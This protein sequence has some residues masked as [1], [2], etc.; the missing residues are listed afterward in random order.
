VDIPR[1]AVDAARVLVDLAEPLDPADFKRL[2]NNHVGPHTYEM[3]PG[4]LAWHNPTP[5]P[6]EGDLEPVDTFTAWQALTTRNPYVRRARMSGNPELPEVVRLDGRNDIGQRAP[7]ALVAHPA[8]ANARPTFTVPALDAVLPRKRPAYVSDAH[9]LTLGALSATLAADRVEAW[10]PDLT[11]GD[12]TKARRET[13]AYRAYADSAVALFPQAFAW[14]D[15][16]EVDEPVPAF[17]TVPVTLH[18]FARKGTTE[19]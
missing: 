11:A 17:Q 18:G 7:V 5:V 6:R 10:I 2:D 4:F 1:T 19:E 8:R 15:A 12:A 16:V 14:V 13:V 9:A 3:P